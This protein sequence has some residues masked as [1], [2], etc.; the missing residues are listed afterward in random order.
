MS[1]LSLLGLSATNNKLQQISF[2][3]DDHRWSDIVPPQSALTFA[4]VWDPDGGMVAFSGAELLNDSSDHLEALSS[5]ADVHD[6]YSQILLSE[7]SEVSSPEASSILLPDHEYLFALGTPTYERMKLGR[8]Q[9]SSTLGGLDVYLRGSILGKT[10]LYQHHY[11]CLDNLGGD[12]NFDPRTS[13]SKVLDSFEIVGRCEETSISGAQYIGY[14]LGSAR[15]LATTSSSN[16]ISPKADDSEYDAHSMSWSALEK[17]T[18]P[19]FTS[20]MPQAPPTKTS[21]RRLK[22]RRPSDPT[23]ST[24][25]SSKRDNTFAIRSPRPSAANFSLS[26]RSRLSIFPK[27]PSCNKIKKV[28]DSSWVVVDVN[29]ANETPD[30]TS[31]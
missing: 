21:N 23:L 22:K 12:F 6:N 20:F 24:V 31:T 18:T 1:G 5:P 29:E 17:P 30:Q 14:D 13:F 28:I 25:S 27:L 11:S 9:T 3:D 10:H 2:T 16:Y 19:G 8:T 4:V 26:T 15:S 7:S